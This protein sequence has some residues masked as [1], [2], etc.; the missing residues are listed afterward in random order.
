[1]S[2]VR[3]CSLLATL[4]L[5]AALP[6]AT[7]HAAAPRPSHAICV[8][9]RATGLGQDLGEGR[10]QATISSHGHV[11]GHTKAVFAIGQ[12]LGTKASF[13]G[14][15]TFTSAIGTLTAQVAGTF[16]VASGAFSATSTSLTGTGLLR[17]ST[18]SV[19][20]A[21]N[22]DV[23]IGTFTETITGRLCFGG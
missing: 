11:I 16:D 18:G 3:T 9:I 14:P 13:T 5:V 23:A 10:T 19:T 2:H 22:E 15:I 20:L 4:A 6:A 12:V 7:A 1:M 8:P 21:G 17:R